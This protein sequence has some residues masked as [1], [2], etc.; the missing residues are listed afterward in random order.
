MNE[1]VTMQVTHSLGELGEDPSRGWRGW[2]SRAYK[3]KEISMLGILH[4]QSISSWD[5][6][7]IGTCTLESDILLIFEHFDDVV[8]VE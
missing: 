6:L 2:F 8:M 5:E 4:D 1:I 7:F 3:L